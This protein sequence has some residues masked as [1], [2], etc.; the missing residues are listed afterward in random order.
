MNCFSQYKGSIGRRRGFTVIE[1]LIVMGC[2]AILVS[3]LLPA[4]QQTR[5]TASRI[6]CANRLRQVALATIMHADTQGALPPGYTTNQPGA[7]Y[8]WMTWL[9]RILPG[10][11]QS[12][13]WSETTGAYSDDRFPFGTQAHRGFHTPLTAFTCPMDGRVSFTAKSAEYG[14]VALSSYVGNGGTD[15][16]ARD[17]VFSPDSKIR[18]ADIDDGLSNT[19]LAGERPPS[20]DLQ[21]GWWYAG[22]GQDGHGSPDMFLGSREKN[23]GW[24]GN[25]LCPPGPYEF[26]AG[27]T[28]RQCDVFHFWSLH[29]GGAW[30][31]RCDGS[32]SFLPYSANEIL[33]A[34]AT[35]SSGEVGTEQ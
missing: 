12:S 2:I 35:R 24:S 13:L 34:L 4:V 3:L 30:F 33:P 23:I 7:D 19:L 11:D 28:Q 8:P 10:I 20:A 9:C 14:P 6:E 17:G 26:Q 27:R 22:F 21:Y 16:L 32:V 18:F 1:L 25:E 15:Y 29:A 31:A 5:N